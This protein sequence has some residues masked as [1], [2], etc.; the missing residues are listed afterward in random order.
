[1]V[2]DRVDVPRITTSYEA[3]LGRLYRDAAPKLWR[4]LDG[5][6]RTAFRLATSE[7][8]AERRQPPPPPDAVSGID[9]GEVI[10]IV[11]ALGTLSSRQ[12]AAV[13]LHDQEGFTA[14][15]AGRLLRA[16]HSS[17]GTR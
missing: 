4:S 8:K 13:I 10:D 16:R 5:I 17:S 15:E 2:D 1:M 9:P 11:R 14:P 3:E 12:R 7:L 6:Y